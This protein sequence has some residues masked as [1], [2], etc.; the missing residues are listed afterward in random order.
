MKSSSWRCELPFDSAAVWEVMTDLTQYAWRS[1]I[2]RIETVD[3]LTFR[4]IYP[5]GNETVFTITEKSRIHYMPS[6]WK[7]NGFPGTGQGGCRVLRMA[8][9]C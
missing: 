7:T 5:N 2:E 6:I 1:D 4:E 8:A 9:V 3:A